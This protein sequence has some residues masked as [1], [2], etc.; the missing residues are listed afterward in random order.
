MMTKNRPEGY[1]FQAANG[2]WYI[3]QNGEFR[4]KHHVIAEKKYNTA[5]DTK[6]HRVLFK[7][8]N[9]ENLDPSN[10]ILVEKKNGRLK[11]I[12]AIKRKIAL[13]EEELADL[14]RCD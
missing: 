2:Y 14:E 3:K 13:L 4:L 1:E 8:R 5:V 6:V 11:R 9:R 12:E 7:D 10:I